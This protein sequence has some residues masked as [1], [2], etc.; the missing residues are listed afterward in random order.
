[1]LPLNSP[2]TWAVQK[3]KYPT[4]V[5]KIFLPLC[6]LLLSSLSLSSS[7]LPVIS[8]SSLVSELFLTG[9]LPTSTLK[10]LDPPFPLPRDLTSGTFRPERIESIASRFGVDT[11][12]CLENI[13][14]GKALNSESG[15]YPLPFIPLA[16][17]I[18]ADGLGLLY[19]CRWTGFI[20][21]FMRMGSSDGGWV[22]GLTVDINRLSL[23]IWEEHSLKRKVSIDY[24]Y[25]P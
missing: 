23:I 10:A 3:E 22:D 11:K 9:R 6:F 1:V 21:C 5:S 2:A 13:L 20:P 16:S 24:L 25:L 4:T 17:F 18:F 7:W 15:L 12:Q 8:S 19:S 14:V